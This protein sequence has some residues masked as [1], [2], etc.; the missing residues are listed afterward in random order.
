[1]LVEGAIVSPDGKRLAAWGPGDDSPHDQRIRL[2]NAETGKELSEVR[3]KDDGMILAAAFAPDSR[4]LA[5][6]TTRA[7]LQF[8]PC[9]DGKQI[10]NIA[11]DG[12]RPLVREKLV[13]TAPLIFSSDGSQIALGTS[14]GIVRV[15]DA[16]SGK[17]LRTRKCLVSD[18]RSFTF[19]DGNVVA[20]G[21]VGDSISVWDERS[22]S[23]F[24]PRE[25]HAG[26]VV[27][28]MFSDDGKV[29]RSAAETGDLFRW[30]TGSAIG[31]RI[32]MLAAEA[33]SVD[34]LL[35]RRIAAD[36]FGV[37][38]GEKYAAIAGVDGMRLWDI[39][40]GRVVQTFPH[41]RTTSPILAFADRGDLLALPN[42]RMNFFDVPDCVV[43]ITLEGLP[44]R[45]QCTTSSPDGRY[46]A[47]A[48]AYPD[49]KQWWGDATEIRVW[50][51]DDGQEV[52]RFSFSHGFPEGQ[53]A[54]QALAL[55]PNGKLV[56]AVVSNYAVRVW[57]TEKTTAIAYLATDE[58]TPGPLCFSP[59]G[60]LLAVG[61]TIINK[62]SGQPETRHGVIQ[63]WEIASRTVWR[64]FRGHDG[65][66]TALALSG[67]GR[68][69]ASGSSDTT[70]LIWD[71]SGDGLV[72][73]RDT[74]LTG[75]Q[76]ETLWQRLA[77]PE[78]GAGYETILRLC[79][80]PGDSVELL[81][82]HLK[83]VPL[84]PDAPEMVRL[85]KRLD[86]QQEAERTHAEQ[87]VMEAGPAIVPAL[88]KAI[89]ASS[90]PELR[91]RAEALLMRI[92]F[93]E[94][95][96]ETPEDSIRPTRALAT[97]QARDLVRSLSLGRADHPLTLEAKSVLAR[98]QQQ[99]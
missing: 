2:S 74:K 24:E 7:K 19:V 97:P 32:A 47:A 31:K 88:R 11:C 73:R 82:S 57:N 10:S 52:S 94:T 54:N 59:D 75:T 36:R 3:L 8:F 92:L 18:V 49:P 20:C 55:S 76:K 72:P 98:M 23:K 38:L 78:A 45:V 65:A 44:G 22:R 63:L 53:D 39:S 35:G 34:R 29:L 91:K 41:G 56:A 95:P 71:V 1:M 21:L 68:R 60:R 80:A 43:R 89:N 58:G 96:P 15:W 86:S 28:L 6:L 42:G 77:S 17:P 85:V 61:R 79:A 81:R 16:T 62:E 37:S 87:R 33:S 66:V 83:P 9:A 93:W 27:S 64:E 13:E 5:I 25:G 46:V 12:V 90:S 30:D 51:A 99:R 48:A 70:I 14:D 4:R 26:R 84:V 40:A 69:L 67:D 50:R